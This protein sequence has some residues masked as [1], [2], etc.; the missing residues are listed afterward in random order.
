VPITSLTINKWKN[1]EDLGGNMV[2]GLA[3]T[4]KSGAQGRKKGV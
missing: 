1:R 4:P 2:N 3:G